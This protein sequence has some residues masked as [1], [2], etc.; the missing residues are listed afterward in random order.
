MYGG[1][2]PIA[3][4]KRKSKKKATSEA[5]EDEEASEPKPKKAKK[6]KFVQ[7]V[8]TSM[9][10]IQEEA[11]EL[12][13]AKILNR[14]TRGGNSTGSS[15]SLP[16]QPSIPR[17]KRK[18]IRK[19]VLQEE[20]DAEIEAATNLVTREVRRKKAADTAALQKTL[21]IAKEIEVPAEALLKESIVENAQKIVEL[22]GN[23]QELV[24][25]GELL[26]DTEEAQKEDVACSDVGTS[27]AD[28]SR[29]TRGNTDSHN[30]SDNVI[31]VES[32]SIST[33]NTNF[34]STSSDIDD[35]PLNRV[36]ENLHKSLA[37]SSSTKHLKKHDDD[38]FVP[39][40]PYVLDR[41]ANMSQLRI[42]VCNRLPANHP[43][44]PPMVEPL[45]TIPADAE[46]GSEQA[47]PESDNHVSSSQ[48][49]PTTQTSDPSVLEELTN[50]YSSEL[51]GFEPN[52]ERAFELASEEAV[53]ESPQQQ[54]PNSQ[55]A[56]NTCS[57]LIIHP[58]FQL[59][60]LNAT[61]SNISF[62]IA[63][64]NLAN[65]KSSSLKSPA[66]DNN[67]S[68]SEETTLVVQPLNVAL[69]SVSSEAT[70]E[71]QPSHEHSTRRDF[72]ITSVSDDEDE[73]VNQWFKP[74][75]LNQSLS[76]SSPVVL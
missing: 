29:A 56:S 69:P 70:L 45:Q 9:P 12:E 16:P 51:P 53:S 57:E 72:I 65:K 5:T 64:R 59:Y 42:D 67:P 55:M 38:T 35:I 17:K 54:E 7:G 66:S 50:H 75:F 32:S 19:K 41:I 40:Y 27:E 61:H 73:Q 18:K 1:S 23:L 21:E 68:L 24:V 31:E 46:V 30:I 28:A 44:Q 6:E 63:L 3:S 71:A 33:S 49:Q 60:H 39:M 47:E 26:N 58:E 2:L 15:Q 4:K 37:P 8:G 25:V 43:L 34:V 11:Q 14:R 52:F 74:V 62:G 13:P 22:A 20:V 76:S 10:T 48:P 36:Y